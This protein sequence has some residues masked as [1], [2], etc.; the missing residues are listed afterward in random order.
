[1]NTLERLNNWCGKM[2][3]KSIKYD[4]LITFTMISLM[5]IVMVISMVM[6][7]LGGLGYLQ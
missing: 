4:D 1:M 2:L 6:G 3:D 7:I 5:F